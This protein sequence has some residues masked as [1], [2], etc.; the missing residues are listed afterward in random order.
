MNTDEKRLIVMLARRVRRL[1]GTN[2]RVRRTTCLCV[3]EIDR[4][5]QEVMIRAIRESRP[6]GS[7][8]ESAGAASR[9]PAVFVFVSRGRGSEKKT[10]STA[11]VGRVTFVPRTTDIENATFG[12]RKP[13]DDR[14]ITIAYTYVRVTDGGRRFLF[15]VFFFCFQTIHAN[16][17]ANVRCGRD[18]APA[19]ASPRHG[20]G[21]CVLWYVP[22]VCVNTWFAYAC[23]PCIYT[24]A[25]VQNVC[26]RAVISVCGGGHKSTGLGWSDTPPYHSRNVNEFAFICTRTPHAHSKTERKFLYFFF[27]FFL[28]TRVRTQGTRSY[29]TLCDIAT[30]RY[31]ENVRMCMRFGIIIEF[32]VIT[33]HVH[34]FIKLGTAYAK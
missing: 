34:S 12:D 23:V 14:E 1:S 5:E 28:I 32:I 16:T 8:A 13:R 10:S 19:K 31:A 25:C 20:P 33:R 9:L 4:R 3:R 27:L 30:T 21:V 17:H 11:A 7:D 22:C 15:F 6:S 18:G 2:K 29:R 26:T 24:H